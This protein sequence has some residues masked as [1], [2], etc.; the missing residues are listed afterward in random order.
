MGTPTHRDDAWR[1]AF[2]RD[3]PVRAA[4]E[5]V[6][7]NEQVLDA[8]GLAARISS[9]SF[10]ARCPRRSGRL[11]TRIREL[12]ADG[13]VTVPYRTEVHVCDAKHA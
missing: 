1:A 8:D 10:I 2:E 5:H 3:D 4:R 11:L 6:F 12:T 7:P 13:P 9:I